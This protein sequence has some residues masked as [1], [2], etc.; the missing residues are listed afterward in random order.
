MSHP[1]RLVL[2]HATRL[3]MEPIETALRANWPEVEVLPILEEGLSID[4]AKPEACD[5]DLDR[6]IVAL[7]RYA[8][9]LHP[10]GIL[11]T[12]SA[13]GA[14]IEQ[15]ARSSPVPVLKP[16]ESMFKQALA[17][18]DR[19]VMIYTFPPAVAGMEQEFRHD[20]AALRP[21]ATIRSVLAPGARE[22]L[23]A[24]DAAEH[25]RIIAATAAAV[26]DADVIL[27]AH[28]S[29]APAGPACR[30][31]TALPVLTSPEAAIAEMKQLIAD[32]KETA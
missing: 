8:E 11:Y 32:R 6:R 19:A 24:G 18:G 1:P 15:A 30:A 2:I 23:Q 22:A 16:N 29:M 20:A 3:A 12:C 27:L 17:L 14:G 28:F 21:S 25:D 5:A 4:R 9:G 7:A 26:Q 31:V 10:D 13:F